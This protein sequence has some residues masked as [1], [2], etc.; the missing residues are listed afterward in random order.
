MGFMELMEPETEFRGTVERE[1]RKRNFWVREKLKNRWVGWNHHQGMS[2][3]FVMLHRLIC[4]FKYFPIYSLF[5]DE[6]R[7][8][9]HRLLCFWWTRFILLKC[10]HWLTEVWVVADDSHLLLVAWI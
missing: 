4:N 2:L 8:M 7:L 6:R 5:F 1:D 3:A 10:F 9:I